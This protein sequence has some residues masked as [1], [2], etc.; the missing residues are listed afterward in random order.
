ML[1][2]AW[3]AAGDPELKL[4]GLDLVLEITEVCLAIDIEFWELPVLPAEMLKLFC[5]VCCC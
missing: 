4:C 2:F 1:T 5:L 3:D